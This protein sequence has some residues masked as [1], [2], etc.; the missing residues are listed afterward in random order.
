[1]KLCV[2]IGRAPCSRAPRTPS[3]AA[4]GASRWSRSGPAPSPWR[5]STASRRTRATTSAGWLSGCGRWMGSGRWLGSG[6]QAP[7]CPSLL[8]VS[9]R[10]TGAMGLCY[11]HAQPTPGGHLQITGAALGTPAL[12]CRQNGGTQQPGR[13]SR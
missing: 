7:R 2:W 6:T 4:M 9:T 5:S 11:L 10:G 1:M 8:W 3:A 12:A 13:S